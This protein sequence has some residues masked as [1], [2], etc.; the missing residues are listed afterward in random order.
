M[1]HPPH[2][3]LLRGVPCLFKGN[4][5]TTEGSV[6]T[7][8]QRKG[9]G[10]AKNLVTYHFLISNT[11]VYLFPASPWVSLHKVLKCLIFMDSCR[12]EVNLNVLC[13]EELSLCMKTASFGML[14]MLSD[15]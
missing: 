10:N 8:F 11:T 9:K 15:I 7:S 1:P 13:Q 5:C 4:S 2:S 12:R 14:K 3:Y 6:L